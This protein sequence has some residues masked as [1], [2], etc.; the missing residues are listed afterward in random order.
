MKLISYRTPS[1]FAGDTVRLSPETRWVGEGCPAAWFGADA[2]P[3][4]ENM[5]AAMS[6]SHQRRF[7][8]GT[9]SV[10]AIGA[11]CQACPP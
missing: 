1:A 6:T 8:I 2:Q 4:I 5:T 9:F 3:D 10:G 7:S 11:P